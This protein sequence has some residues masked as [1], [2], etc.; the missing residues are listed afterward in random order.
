IFLGLLMMASSFTVMPYGRID[1]QYYVQLANCYAKCTSEYGTITKQKRNDGEYFNI[2]VNVEDSAKFCEYGCEWKGIEWSNTS[3]SLRNA[4]DR[5]AH[6]LVAEEMLHSNI[7]NKR[8]QMVKSLYI[9][10]MDVGSSTNDGYEESVEGILIAEI[11]K[12]N[13]NP[14]RYIFQWKQRTFTLGFYDES[15][16]IT[17]SIEVEPVVKVQGMISGVQYRFMLTTVDQNG[18]FGIPIMSEWIEALHVDAPPRLPPSVQVSTGFDRNNGVSALISWP[19]LWGKSPS[20]VISC[21]Y[22]TVI[23]NG[24]HHFTKSF[25]IDGGRGLLLTRLECSSLFTILLSALPTN[26]LQSPATVNTTLQLVTPLCS[27]VNGSER[28]E[29]DA[30]PVEMSIRDLREGGVSIRWAPTNDVHIL[31]HYQ[32]FVYSVDKQVHCSMQPVAFYVDRTSTSAN[33]VLPAEHRCEYLFRVL[34]YDLV[35]RKTVAQIRRF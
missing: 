23:Y 33:V 28:F 31:A 35:G 9:G 26:S 4:Y 29:C 25:T 18:I 12:E 27:Q 6:Y 5:G 2:A 20:T 3:A 19:A 32:V 24:I 8:Q 34:T 30:E 22:R 1:L 11:I 14:T 17:S 21:R 10:C 7:N 16:W 13:S 15:P